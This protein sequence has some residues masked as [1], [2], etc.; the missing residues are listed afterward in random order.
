MVKKKE[1]MATFFTQHLQFERKS[2]DALLRR[3]LDRKPLFS[4]KKAIA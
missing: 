4:N 1:F 3:P 2:L